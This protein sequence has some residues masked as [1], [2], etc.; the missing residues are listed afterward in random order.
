[1]LIFPIDQ[2]PRLTKGKGNKIIGL[3]QAKPNQETDRLAFVKIL[4]KGAGILITAG[5]HELALSPSHWKDYEGIR[6]RRG[7]YLPRGYRNVKTIQ[8][9]QTP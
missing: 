6:G 7:K 4:P 3:A 9:I 2:L 1:M 5:K 8:V